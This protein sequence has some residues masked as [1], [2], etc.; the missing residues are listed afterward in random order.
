MLFIYDEKV[1]VWPGKTVTNI[2]IELRDEIHGRCR[3]VR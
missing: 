3:Q 1:K 2:E